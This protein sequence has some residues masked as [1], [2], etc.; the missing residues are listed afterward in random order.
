MYSLYYITFIYQ[1]QLF[2]D[3]ICNIIYKFFLYT[4]L[5]FDAGFFTLYIKKAKILVVKVVVAVD[6]WISMLIILKIMTIEFDKYVDKCV[7]ILNNYATYQQ[8]KNGYTIN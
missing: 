6:M 2:F 1:I 3:F 8:L 5:L 4:F 7:I